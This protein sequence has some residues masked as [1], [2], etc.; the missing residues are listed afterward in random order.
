MKYSHAY[1]PGVLCAL[2]PSRYATRPRS[3]QRFG[4]L[5]EL[6]FLSPRTRKQTHRQ[7]ADREFCLVE[8]EEG[9]HVFVVRASE[10]TTHFEFY[11]LPEPEGVLERAEIEPEPRVPVASTSLPFACHQIILPQPGTRVSVLAGAGNS[12]SVLLCAARSAKRSELMAYRVS[13]HRRDV[14][15]S[16]LGGQMLPEY[17]DVLDCV[18]G[19]RGVRG[20][21]SIA[22]P[23]A[24]APV[25]LA[26][27]TCQD[28]HFKVEMLK[29]PEFGVHRPVRL[30][31]DEIRGTI[32]FLDD[33]GDMHV[34]LFDSELF[35]SSCM[36]IR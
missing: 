15:L 2:L 5:I 35:A 31:F 21:V 24:G 4:V 10:E 9:P 27:L 17:H 19:E 26:L 16:L 7:A 36:P 11:D 14:R 3:V 13:L 20:V 8:T 1:L 25:E 34:V 28:K 23:R 22:G 30:A 12:T 32:I 33:E 18:L 6:E 29:E